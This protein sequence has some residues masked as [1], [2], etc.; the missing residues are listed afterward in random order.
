MID[1]SDSRE[2]VREREKKY[3]CVCVGRVCMDKNKKKRR[4]IERERDRDSAPELAQRAIVA[5]RVGERGG[6]VVANT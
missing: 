3:E 4:V 5:Q 6:A 2:K 1:R